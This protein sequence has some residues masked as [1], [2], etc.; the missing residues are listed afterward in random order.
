M[1]IILGCEQLSLILA[2][3]KRLFYWVSRYEYF[4]VL[5]EDELFSA[6]RFAFAR[7]CCPLLDL[8]CDASDSTPPTLAELFQAGPTRTVAAAYI[9]LLEAADEERRTAARAAAE[10]SV[11]SEDQLAVE[12]DFVDDVY[13]P[14][15]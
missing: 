3:S 5:E 12:P 11:A 10:P 4:R 13:G 1:Q 14:P 9:A 6:F 8:R 2:N 7:H 15:S